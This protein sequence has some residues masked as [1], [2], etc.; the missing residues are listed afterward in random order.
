MTSPDARGEFE[1]LSTRRLTIALNLCATVLCASVVVLLASAYL[2][3]TV[4]SGVML[5]TSAGCMYLLRTGDKI[6]A[7]M[8]RRGDDPGR[9]T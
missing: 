6:A 3:H 9:S 4:W 2:A 5:M 7:E 1:H 8:R